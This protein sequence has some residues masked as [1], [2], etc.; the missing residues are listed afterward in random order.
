MVTDREEL[1]TTEPTVENTVGSLMLTSELP[2]EVNG[3]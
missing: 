1:I 2:G 3:K